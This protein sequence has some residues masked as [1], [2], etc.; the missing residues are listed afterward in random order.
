MLKRILLVGG[1][2]YLGSHLKKNLIQKGHHVVITGTKLLN[3]ETYLR[4]DFNEPETFKSLKAE[5][6]DLIVILA[7]KLNSLDSEELSHPDFETN[8][9]GLSK[10]LDFI[11]DIDL[12]SKLIYVSSMTVYAQENI[13]PVHEDMARHPLST[14]GLSKK[15][16]EDLTSFFCR[17]SGVKG[18]ILRLPGIYGGGRQGGFIYNTIQRIKAGETITLNT[19][20]LGYWET[21]NI[22]DLVAL[23]IDFI[24]RYKWIENVDTY[25]LAYGEEAD[26]HDTAKY[27]AQCMGKPE[28]IEISGEKGYVKL[29]MDNGKVKDIIEVPYNYYASLTQYINSFS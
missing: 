23:M 6:Y 20:G 28:A 1:S 3:E 14:Y 4:I 13:S 5:S 19:S 25:N 11:K 15:I 29:F 27:I 17:S 10:F 12:T 18:A 9:L 8:V 26:F 2:G 24:N 16:A 22:D 7:S 21:I